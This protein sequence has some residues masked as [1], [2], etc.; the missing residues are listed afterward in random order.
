[1]SSDNITALHT[2]LAGAK[3]AIREREEAVQ[4]S[5]AAALLLQKTFASLNEAVFIVQTGTRVIVD[6][7]KAV[8][9]LFGYTWDEIVGRDTSCLHLNEQLSIRFGREMVTAYQ[10]KGFYETTYQMLRKDG[11]A[12]DSEHCVT[13]IYDGNGEIYRHVCVVRDITERKRSEEQLKM[14]AREQSIILDNACVGI[15]LTRDRRFVWSNDKFDE[16][17]GYDKNELEGQSTEIIYPSKEVYEQ[18]GVQ[19]YA[20][21]AKGHQYVSE[22]QLMRKDGSVFW[23]KYYGKAIDPAHLSAGTIWILEDINDRRQAEWELIRK[24]RQLKDLN[25]NLEMRIS[26]AVEELSRKDAV[27]AS[28][29]KLLIDLAPE[30]IIVFD[31]DLDRIVDANAK[32]EQLFGCSRE[33][34]LASTPR[35]F[36]MQQQPDS[37]PAEASFF[38]NS[39]RVMAGETLVIERAI[40]S[41]S[42][43]EAVC[44][45]RLVRLP[46]PHSLLIR[47][48]FFDI[49]ERAL[50]Q[51]ELTKALATEHRLNEEQRQFMG[52]V[53]HELRTPLSVIDGTAQL[54]VMTACKDKE[55]FKYAERILSSTKRITSLI[56]TCLTEE[57]LCT[58]GWAPVMQPEDIRRLA[59]NAVVHAQSGT[60]QHTISCDLD[61]LPDQ[62]NCDSMLIQVMLSNLLDNAVKY[63][64]EGGTINVRGGCSNDG[65]LFFEVA[66]QGIGIAADQLDKAFDRFY[67]IWQIPGIAGAGLGLHIVKRV[68]ELHGGTACCSSEPGRGSTFTVRLFSSPAS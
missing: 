26:Q 38:E 54:L 32:A 45:V 19:T 41:A 37:R 64:P 20:T 1:M 39:D 49:T 53:S 25:D 44:E 9:T 6:V 40:R 31:T 23:A 51:R 18:S 15:T 50:A 48:S 59:R 42:G 60:A 56:D 46:S 11:T 58:S 68:A 65:E 52:L 43:T 35:Q 63:S 24:S 47:A 27:L 33:V 5:R 13:P 28:Q 3:A 34:L 14:L 4:A 29:N 61:E 57:R 2:A 55:C 16:M 62:Y 66:D 36:Y 67:R 21:V 10:E 30:A 22:L 8:E 12:F 17:F 7:N